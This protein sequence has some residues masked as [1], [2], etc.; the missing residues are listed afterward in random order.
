MRFS[1]LLREFIL[2]GLKVYSV[3]I[4]PGDIGIKA[5]TGPPYLM[6][7]IDDIFVPKGIE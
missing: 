6:E 2:E 7:D 4:I 1:L 3:T 5:N